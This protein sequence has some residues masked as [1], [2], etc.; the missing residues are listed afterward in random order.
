MRVGRNEDELEG[1]N[2]GDASPEDG[3]SGPLMAAAGRA[4]EEPSRAALVQGVAA[5]LEWQQAAGVD[6]CLLARDAPTAHELGAAAVQVRGADLEAPSSAEMLPIGEAEPAGQSALPT[7]MG[8]P[9]GRSADRAGP[10]PAPVAGAR[11]LAASCRTLDELAEA[12][13]RFELCPLKATA[14]R[15]CLCDGNPAARI[16][17]VGE[18]PGLEEDR[19]G[20]PFVG[21]SGKL[22][23]RMLATIG[24]DRTSVYITNAVFWRPP[25]NRAPTEL[26][27]ATCAPFLERQIELLRPAILVFVGGIAARALLGTNEGVTRLRGRRFEY[28]PAR[29]DMPIPARV[30]FHPAYLLRQPMQKKLAWRDL[31]EL[32]AELRRLGLVVGGDTI[33]RKGGDQA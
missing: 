7:T 25:G 12:L 17:L 2:A 8:A 14:T 18:A 19:Q 20:K 11:A 4:G 5:W 29:G 16:M 15:L 13:E 30:I 27:L 22:L 32:A 9:I 10:L 21:A 23:D 26:E 3:R 28:R 24:L 1:R 31:L 33:E 6:C